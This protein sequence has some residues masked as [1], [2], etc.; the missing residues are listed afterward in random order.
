MTITPRPGAHPD[1]VEKALR[2]AHTGAM[3]ARGAH[4]GSP[5]LPYLKWANEAC[6]CCGAR[7]AQRT[8]TGW[9]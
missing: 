5:T 1:N 2:E 7:S 9:C 8:W 4:S 3:N 6:D